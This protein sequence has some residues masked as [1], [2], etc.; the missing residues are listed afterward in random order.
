MQRVLVQVNVGD[1]PRKGGCQVDDALDLVAYAR[2]LPHLTVEGLMTVPPLPPDGTDANAAAR[3]HF[4]TLRALRDDARSRF[5]EVVH[6]SMGM[7]ADLEAA[8]A[9]GAT[10]VRIGTAIFGERGAAPVAA[11]GPPRTDLLAERSVA[12]RGGG[13]H[14]GA[15]M[16][17][18]LWYRTLVYLGLKE[19]PE[20]GY[21]DLPERVTDTSRRDDAGYWEQRPDPAPG[22][23]GHERFDPV[24][25]PDLDPDRPRGAGGD[26]NVRPLRAAD[27]G[28]A[29]P[30]GGV[31]LAV[32]EVARFDDVEQ[33]GSRYRTGQPVLFDVS[34]ADA[35]RPLGAWSTSSRD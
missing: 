19:E 28:H 27:A 4:A 18:G 12:G 32:V 10:M 17:S 31:R 21:D 30:R 33:V 14:G 34:R 8:I 20:E 13:G 24:G 5:P 9:E 2:D 35:R 7:S 23:G 26:S 1:D 16:S 3:P 11:V 15:T 25:D 6:L 29:R 22:I